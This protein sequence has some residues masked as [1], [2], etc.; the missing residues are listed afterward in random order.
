MKRAVLIPAMCVALVLQLAPPASAR[1]VRVVHRG[2]HRTTVIVHRGFPIRRALPLCV[3]RPPRV[4]VVVAPSVYLAP[5][6]WTA[7]VVSLPPRDLLVWEDSETLTRDDDWT[8]FTLNVNDRGTRL[9]LEIDGKAQV[10]FAEVV[11]ANGE[12]VA[13]D[14]AQGTRGAGTYSLLDF[15]DGRKVSHVRMVA[16]AKSDEA[17]LVVRMAK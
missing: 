6:V 13:V 10:E 14:F 17:R 12:A 9:F 15:A 16:R 7:A 5:V 4:A 1:R 11:Y 3:V 8:D 2:P